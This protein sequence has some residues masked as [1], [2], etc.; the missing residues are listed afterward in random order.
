VY[1]AHQ[2]IA[3]LDANKWKII[4][5]C[6]FAMLCNYTWFFAALRAA[7]RDRVY[8]I[9]AFCVLFWL[10]GDSSF[11]WHFDQWFNHYKNWYVELF[12]VA[13]IFTVMFEIAFTVQLI[14]YGRNELLPSAT[15]AQW[16][17]LVIAAI[18]AAIV[19]WSLIRHV[20]VD[21]LWI[22][23]FDLANLVGP[24][25][26]A[27]LILRRRSAAGQTT[28]IWYAYA[29]MATFWFIAEGLWFGS[30]FRSS[31]YI[32]VAV[33]CVG[34]SLAVAYTVG[35]LRRAVAVAAPD[36]AAASPSPSTTS[37]VIASAT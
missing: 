6:T 4:A 16:T 25:F 10:V 29:A 8:S 17:A 1:D 14:Q 31:E 19:I 18:G 27:A 3:Q 15:Q 11:L 36:A 23:Y 20:I 7:R 24:I 22:T 33:L 5:L 2:V 32:A 12:W 34:A 26:A 9:P 35:R 28:L 37:G 13:L 21:P 30:T